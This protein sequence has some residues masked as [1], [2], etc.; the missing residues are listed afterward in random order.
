MT[1]PTS[2][3]PAPRR[4]SLTFTQL[5]LGVLMSA[6]VFGITG[7]LKNQPIL[8]DVGIGF[9]VLGVGM[10]IWGRYRKRKE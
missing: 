1:D 9:A 4:W 2:P 5:R 10:R 8:F 3:A 6:L 7:M